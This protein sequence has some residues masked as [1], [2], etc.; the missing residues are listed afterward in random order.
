MIKVR[1][2]LS[3]NSYSYMTFL[4]QEGTEYLK[5]YLEMRIKKGEKLKPSSPVV[6]SNQ[7]NQNFIGT[8]AIRTGIRKSFDK[9]GLPNRPYVLRR[10]FASMLL[11]GESQLKIPHSYGQFMM[12]HQGEMMDIYT[13]Q[14]GLLVEDIDSIREAY[15]KCR[16]Y[17]Q[18]DVSQEEIDAQNTRLKQVETDNK[19]LGNMLVERLTEQK[20]LQ[21]DLEKKIKDL[22][23]ENFKL[24]SAKDEAKNETGK[25]KNELKNLMK[26]V[27]DIQ[28]EMEKPPEY[29]EVTEEN[30]NELI[31]EE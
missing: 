12:G 31:G 23:M 5:N 15:R 28:K 26:A 3:K 29:T 16:T 25:M 8:N 9:A 30:M 13:L 21:E 14:K 6:R 17:L 19:A 1:E 7:K 24:S 20:K 10:Y 2:E 11:R 4:C 18:T 22:E 27:I